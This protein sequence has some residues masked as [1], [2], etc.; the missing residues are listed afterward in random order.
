MTLSGTEVRTSQV[1]TDTIVAAA[2]ATTAGDLKIVVLLAYVIDF[3][4]FSGLF[5]YE[6]YASS[7][8]ILDFR[9]I[10]GTYGTSSTD[11]NG[12]EYTWSVTVG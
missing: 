1:E 10:R 3:G 11:V 12:I 2:V 5:T 7:W 4:S 6:I 9:D 8:T